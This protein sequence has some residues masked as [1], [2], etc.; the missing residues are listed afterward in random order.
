MEIRRIR[1]DDVEAYREVRLRA[2]RL[3]PYAFSTT[4]VDASSRDDEAWRGATARLAGEHVAGFAVDRG[5]GTFGG[6]VSVTIEDPAAAEVNQMWL[7]EDLRGGDWGA[8]LLGA[9]EGFATAADI[10]R[11]TLWVAEGNERTARFYARCGYAATGETE[12]FP[13]GGLELQ[14]AKVLVPPAP[15]S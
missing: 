2:L 10:G 12:A 4:F 3:A 9:C 5:D 11:L 15:A 8:A 7:D 6:L 1:P 14:L 13:G